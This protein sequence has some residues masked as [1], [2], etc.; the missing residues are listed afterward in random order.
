MS[1]RAAWRLERL[2][3]GEVYDF[4]VGKAA[5]LAMGWPREGTAA[6]TPNAGDVARKD[7]PTCLLDD[8]VGDVREKVLEVGRDVCIVIN[9][10]R[11][12]QGRLKVAALSG[13]PD[14]TAE[15]AMELGPTTVR[16]NEPLAPLVDR[17]KNRGVQTI[18]VT[19]LRGKLFGI[20]HRNDAERALMK[21]TRP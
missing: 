2:G 20:L 12:V 13:N 11:I 18:V 19:D 9:S 6:A 15:E 4:S 1:P 10:E 14:V 3:F 8:R 5:W 17:M 7:T 16:P 21:R